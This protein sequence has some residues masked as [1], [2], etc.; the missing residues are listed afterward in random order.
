M[1]IRYIEHADRP[2]THGRRGN[3]WALVRKYESACSCRD[4]LAAAGLESPALERRIARMER[5]LNVTRS[6]SERSDRR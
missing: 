1:L 6:T 5:L 4:L 3:F 2:P